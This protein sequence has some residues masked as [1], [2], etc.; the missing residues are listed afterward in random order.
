MH[1]GFFLHLLFLTQALLLSGELHVQHHGVRV[2]AHWFL[3][4]SVVSYASAPSLG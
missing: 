3:S 1:I 4:P 2:H